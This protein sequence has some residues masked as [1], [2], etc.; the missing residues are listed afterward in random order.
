MPRAVTTTSPSCL[1]SWSI[2]TLI[3]DSLPI[4][5]SCVAMPTEEN[6]SVPPVAGTGRLK[7]PSALVEMPVEVPF[8]NTVTPGRPSPEVLS[9][10][11]PETVRVCAIT[12]VR[13]VN[14][15]TK[16]MSKDFFMGEEFGFVMSTKSQRNGNY[17]Q[18]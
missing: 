17:G 13:N 2:A 9:V 1:L 3:C 15:S 10:I 11:R 6:T 14:M 4:A 16:L 8:S 12:P 5:R 18:K 7:L